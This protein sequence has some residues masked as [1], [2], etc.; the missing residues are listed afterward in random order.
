MRHSPSLQS[1]VPQV[2]T[3]GP[4]TART[5]TYRC[6]PERN[7]APARRSRRTRGCLSPRASR[8]SSGIARSL[9]LF[10]S[11]LAV[12][13]FC[14]AQP[15][16]AKRPM[17]FEDMMQMK[18]LGDTAVSP[19]GKWLAYSVTTV[20]LAQNTKTLSCGCRRLRAAN[21]SRSPSRSR[22]TPACSFRSDGK[23]ILFLSSRER[24]AAGVDRGLRHGHGRGE[25]REEAD[26]DRDRGRQRQVV[27]RRKSI[28][29]HLGRLS[30]LPRDHVLRTSEQ[31][32]V[33]CRRET[34]HWPTAR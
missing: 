7:L 13:P 33:Q 9:L 5:Q 12:L 4:G 21:R 18:R 17:T 24:R 10:A 1:R 34:R 8:L 28:V 30:G 22:A 31:G 32:T 3:F 20:D 11:F 2:R 25:Q 19:D 14:S 26:G 6:H 16:P 23:R 15:A 27:A 29:F